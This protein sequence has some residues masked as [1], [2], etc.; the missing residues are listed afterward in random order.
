MAG[1][2]VTRQVPAPG[3][4]ARAWTPSSSSGTRACS[5]S[6]ST[7][8]STRPAWIPR[9]PTSPTATASSVGR[10]TSGSG[11]PRGYRRFS[12]LSV[13][14]GEFT[15]APEGVS[16][17]YVIENE[18]TYLAFPI[19]PGAMVILVVAT[20]SRSC[21]LLAIRSRRRLLGR[22]RHAWLRDPQ[23]AAPP[24][25]QR[26]FHAHGPGHS[27]GPPGALE[28]EP[29]P[30]GAVLDR[31]NLAESALYA[32]LISDAYAPTVRLE[33]EQISFSA[34]EKQTRRRLTGSRDEPE[35]PFA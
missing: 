4:C 12:E 31:L 23:P 16:R 15:A 20:H 19:P 32:D 26:P 9:R 22:R 5:P 24:P 6:F 11:W 29:S 33:Q 7:S 21:R 1:G 13:R 30:A 28:T 25:T 3:R 18:I 2:Q 27:A 17:A 34:V 10:V 35:W 14:A 8:S